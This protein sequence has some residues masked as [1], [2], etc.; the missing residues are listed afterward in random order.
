M[1]RL[2]LKAIVMP[3]V[4]HLARSEIRPI[5]A[6]IALRAFMPSNVMQLPDGE[7][8]GVRFTAELCRRLPTFELLLSPNRDDIART[9]AG[10]I[11]QL[12]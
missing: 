7:A 1:D 3:R 4:A 6:P 10:L 2:A 8:V 12:P 9:I 5:A 11:G